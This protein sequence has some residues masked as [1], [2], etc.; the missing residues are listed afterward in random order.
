MTDLPPFE[1]LTD[2]ALKV[3]AL[4][5]PEEERTAPAGESLAI[6]VMERQGG[7]LFC[8]PCGYL[9]LSALDAGQAAVVDAVMGPPFR[10]PFRSAPPDEQGLEVRLELEHAVLIVDFSVAVLPLLRDMGDEITGGRPVP[11]CLAPARCHASGRRVFGTPCLISLTSCSWPISSQALPPDDFVPLWTRESPAETAAL[12]ELWDQLGLLARAF[13]CYKAADK[14]RRGQN[15][16]E[17]RLSGPSLFI[18]VG[19][20]LGMLEADPARQCLRHLCVAE[21][22]Y[23]AEG[24]AGSDGKDI[25]GQ[26]FARVAGAELNSSKFARACGLI[27]VAAPAATRAA[28]ALVSSE[29]ARCGSIT[30]SLLLSL[31]GSWTS[32]ALFRRPLMSIF[33]SSVYALVA[34]KDVK[35][36]RPTLC[37]LTREAA[38][39]LVFTAARLCRPCC[40]FWVGGLCLYATDASEGK[41]GYVSE[42]AVLARGLRLGLALSLAHQYLG[43][44]L[45]SIL[46]LLRSLAPGGPRRIVIFVDSSVAFHACAK[47]R[48]PSLGL[49]PLLRKICAVCLLAGLYPSFHYVPTRLDSA[50]CPTRD[51]NLP[52]PSEESFWDRL[53]SD[54]LYEGL[55]LAKLRRRA[56]NWACLV[57]LVFGCPPAFRPSL[58]WRSLRTTS[59]LFDSSLGFPGEGPSFRVFLWGVICFRAVAVAAAPSHVLRPRHSADEKR[60]AARSTVLPLEGRPVEPVTQRR[61]DKLLAAFSSWWLQGQDLCFE[62]LLDMQPHN[63]CKL[64]NLLLMYGRQLF[65]AGWPFSHYSEVINAIASR[66]PSIR[67]S[68]QPAWDLAFAWLREEPHSRHVALPW[69]LLLSAITIALMWGWPRVARTSMVQSLSD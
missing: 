24:L 33:A 8:I 18:P 46:R 19:P 40:F 17:S 51:L 9:S 22:I 4:S 27:T 21:E 62:Q 32:T 26:D 23:S 57:C 59:R 3:M 14:G 30:D 16:A 52:P 34:A 11:S 58:G 7:V 10:P 39:E 60:S 15:F 49:M 67:W 38:Q 31:V 44:S 61:R 66:E 29:A 45:D 54:E 12:A 42:E 37:A 50:D 48:S 63:I 1:V 36:S 13:N 65:E 28:L 2:G 41:G 43:D 6:P 56:S 5:W 69:Q 35:A 47:G 68:L 20:T 64:N 55:A 25:V 53:S